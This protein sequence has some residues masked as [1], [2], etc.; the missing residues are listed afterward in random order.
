MPADVRVTFL[1]GLGDIGRNCAV[2]ETGDDAILLDCGQLFPD[3][4]MPG[5]DAVLPDFSYLRQRGGRISALVATHGHED[6]IGAIAHALREFHF[7]IYGSA[8]TVGLVRHRLEE[9]GLAQGVELHTLADGDRRRIGPFEIE[10]VPVTHSVPSGLI[11]AIHTPQGVILHSSDFKLDPDPVD[12]RLTDLGRVAEISADPGIRLLLADST[13]SEIPGSTLPERAIGPVLRE[14]FD[15]S[16]GRRVITACFSSHVHRVQQIVDAAVATGRRV[17]TLGM[18]MKRNFALARELGLLKMSDAAWID[19]EDTTDLDPGEVCIV[20]TGS[21]GEPRSALALA[22]MGDSRWIEVGPDDTVVLSSHP[23]PGNEAK[24]ARMIDELVQRGARVV[25]SG[26][27]ELH[28]SGHGKQDELTE[29]HRA[30]RPEWFVP[31]HGEYRHLVAHAE[32]A[33]GLGMPGERVLVARDGDQVVLSDDGLAL[34]QG[35]TTGRHVFVDGD[36]TE[37]DHSLFRERAVLGDNGVVIATVGVDL[38]SGRL[39]GEP[40][41][42]SRGWLGDAHLDELEAGGAEAVAEAVEKF[43]ATEWADADDALDLL[44]RRIRR[45]AGQYVSDRSGR[46]P[47]IVP[48]VLT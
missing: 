26:Q 17:A 23:I 27:L 32:L 10:F 20:S 5:A 24:V 15:A 39:V 21:Q 3:E 19:I 47:M 36:L 48:I 18:S 9:T 12:G 28:T 11:S 6:H 4:S 34:A 42:V 2:I 40:R 25:H 35:A 29:L 45:A 41:L 38:D 31:V 33:R 8:F 44:H 30:A 37:H 14:V 43:L 13:N 1:G 7:P 16:A 22:A 46:R